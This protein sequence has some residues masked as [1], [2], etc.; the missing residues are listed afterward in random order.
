MFANRKNN[1]HCRTVL[2][3]CAF[4]VI[5]IKVGLLHLLQSQPSVVHFYAYDPADATTHLLSSIGENYPIC[6]NE[7]RQ[8]TL[9]DSRRKWQTFCTCL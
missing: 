7:M 1:T 6:L 9:T 4:R 2:L 8:L 3:Q 5:T